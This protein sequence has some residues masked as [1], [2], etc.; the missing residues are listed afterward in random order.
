MYSALQISQILNANTVGSLDG[1]DIEW[2]SIDSRSVSSGHGGLFFAIKSEKN[3][4]HRFIE[5]LAAKGMRYFVVQQVPVFNGSAELTFF[6]VDD[7]IAELQCLA[8]FHRL[9]FNCPVIAITGSNGKTIVKEWLWQVLQPDFHLVRSPKSYNSQVGVPL[10]V[11]RMNDS[12]NLAIFEAGISQPGEMSRLERVIQP[13]IGIFTNI[14]AAHEKNFTSEQEKIREKFKLFEH[15]STVIMPA[16]DEKVVVE[17]MKT[18]YNANLIGWSFRKKGNLNI[19]QEGATLECQWKGTEFTVQAPFFDEASIENIITVMTAALHLGVPPK[20]LSKRIPHL[21]A[22][23]MRLEMLEGINNSQLINDSYSADL[24]SLQIALDFLQQQ[25]LHQRKIL[26]ISDIL[27]AGMA[28]ADLYKQVAVLCTAKGIDEIHA[29]GPRIGAFKT[30]FNKPITTYASTDEFLLAFH[31]GMIEQSSVLIK[32]ARVFSFER[33]TKALQQRVHETVLEINLNAVAGNFAAL[34]EAVPGSKV[35]AM[36]KA[37]AYG[38]GNLEIAKLLEYQRVD[39]LGVAYTS[40]GVELRKSGIKTPIM[41]MNPDPN[42]YEWLLKNRLEPEVFNINGL[43]AWQLAIDKWPKETDLGIHLKMDTGMHRL[44][45]MEH[46]WPELLRFLEDHPQV[47]IKSVFSHLAAADEPSFDAFTHQQIETFRRACEWLKPVWQPDTIRHLANTSA[48]LRFPEAR[49]DMVRLGIGLYGVAP[50]PEWKGKLVLAGR[51]KT[52]ISQIREVKVGDSVGYN[53]NHRVDAQN[54]RIATVPIGY[55]DGLPRK[56]GN[57]RFSLWVNGKE[58]P[59]VGNVCMDMCMINVSG[60][61][62]SEGDEVIVFGP[63]KPIDHLA[64][65]LETIPY[66]VL[67]GISSRVKRVFFQ[68]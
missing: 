59:I 62:C 25:Q 61:S 37:A 12:H 17:W 46:E 33:I 11:W 36:V 5:E 9:Q 14:G 3:D 47:K 6:V 44:G 23:G 31:P 10:S 55:A 56:L 50:I 7:V 58:A 68:E 30:V 54:Q 51:L 15:C 60:I 4:G 35:M 67:T 65:A 34:K 45:F 41:V 39:Y 38:A 53:R 8:A 40:E 1:P 63:E 27:E 2:L 29:I 28:D 16:D 19:R 66:E 57:Q 20:V 43:K 13:Q 64:H 18:G 49:F 22:V 24:S 42:H 26:I 32:G 52:H 21:T 48:A